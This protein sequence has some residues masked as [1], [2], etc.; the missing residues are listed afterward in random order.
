[1]HAA[2]DEARAYES[3]LPLIG[4]LLRDPGAFEPLWRSGWDRLMAGVESFERG[5]STA[6]NLL[7]G[8]LSVVVLDPSI[9]S[10][11]RFHPTSGDVPS[12][13]IA[14]RARG[15]WIDIAVRRAGGWTWRVE[16]AFHASADTV[17]RPRYNRRP[18]APSVA[19]LAAREPDGRGTW[20]AGRG[21]SCAWSS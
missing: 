21:C 1:M 7:D 20:R 6:T 3:V 16:R 18:A 15:E 2:S 8:R 17:V 14:T 9:A 4:R 12:I 19:A 13:A 5:A 10:G 11:G